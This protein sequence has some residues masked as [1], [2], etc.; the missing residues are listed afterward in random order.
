M[1]TVPGMPFPSVAPGGLAGVGGIPI[2]H[3]VVFRKSTEAGVDHGIEQ[4]NLG[5][6]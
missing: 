6:W 3:L 5:S 2:A 1:S 4:G